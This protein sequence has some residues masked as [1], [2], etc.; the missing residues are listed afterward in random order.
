MN[1]ARWPVVVLT[2]AATALAT[3]APG[4]ATPGRDISAEILS[5]ATVNGHDYVVREI[6]I[7]PGGSTGWHW[8]DGRVFGVITAGTLTHNN[9]DC[10]VDGI[11]RPGDPITEASGPNHA[12]V[13]R[14]LGPDPL[15]LQVVYI[16][17]AGS[18]LSEDAADPGCGYD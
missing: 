7:Q 15:V 16:D 4:L 17:P 14:N 3:S 9:F 8:H 5:Q 1:P 12:H 6:T 2:V 13:G 10:T 11:Y 18:P